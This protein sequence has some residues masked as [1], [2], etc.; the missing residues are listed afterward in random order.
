[1]KTKMLRKDDRLRPRRLRVGVA[2]LALGVL[3]GVSVAAA[4]AGP[5]PQPTRLPV[6][7]PTVHPGGALASDNRPASPGGPR[8]EPRAPQDPET[9]RVHIVRDRK[10]YTV[11]APVTYEES[12]DSEGRK[13]TKRII[14]GDR[15]DQS[16]L[17]PLPDCTEQVQVGCLFPE[18]RQRPESPPR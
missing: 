15:I 12:V 14:H 11:E 4:L 9:T 8:Q 17:P 7:Q 1:M 16:Q 6:R 3:G 13:L 2:L 10:V 18:D 5:A